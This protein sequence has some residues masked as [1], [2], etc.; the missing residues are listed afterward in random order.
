MTN[1]VIIFSFQSKISEIRYSRYVNGTNCSFVITDH[2]TPF[3]LNIIRVPVENLQ[4][5]L[6]C[7]KSAKIRLIEFGAKF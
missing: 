5:D 1:P 4:I 3:L 6:Q 7:K 2:P